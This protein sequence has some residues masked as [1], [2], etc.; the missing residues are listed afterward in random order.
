MKKKNGQRI[1]CCDMLILTEI[2]CIALL[3]VRAMR[4]FGFFIYK[5]Y[6]RVSCHKSSRIRVWMHLTTHP[7]EH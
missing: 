4:K 7:R 1:V 3:P 2:P 6:V 5:L